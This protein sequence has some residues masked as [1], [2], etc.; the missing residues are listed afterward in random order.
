MVRKN[1]PHVPAHALG[2]IQASRSGIES[3]RSH[4]T[5]EG[6]VDS[7]PPDSV[8]ARSA[9]VSAAV[10]SPPLP[11]SSAEFLSIYHQN[12]RPSIKLLATIHSSS[13]FRDAALFFDLAGR[14]P[15][16]AFDESQYIMIS[17]YK[18][19]IHAELLPSRTEASLG[20]AFTRTYQFFKDLG[21][22]IQ[23][24]VLDNECPESLVCFFKQQQVT[25]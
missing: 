20:A 3:S 6:A 11:T 1:K 16:T 21:H 2:H 17:Q 5:A 23:F 19:Y 9:F 14:F 24:Q 18:T 7:K 8:P 25:V 4:Q 13:K 12:E 15:V 10:P 22:Q